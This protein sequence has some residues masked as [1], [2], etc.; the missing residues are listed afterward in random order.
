[1]FDLVLTWAEERDLTFCVLRAFV[2]LGFEV[3]FAERTV[4]EF[5]RGTTLR[6]DVSFKATLE[7]VAARAFVVL[8]TTPRFPIGAVDVEFIV[9]VEVVVLL[10]FVFVLFNIYG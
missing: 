2:N 6:A 7:F 4:T 5:V 1:M 9:L 3:L 10:D 8:F